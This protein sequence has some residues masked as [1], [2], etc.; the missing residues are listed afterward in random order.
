MTFPQPKLASFGPS[1]QNKSFSESFLARYRALFAQNPVFRLLCGGSLNLDFERNSV[2]MSA[3]KIF[4]SDSQVTIFFYRIL[5]YTTSALKRTRFRNFLTIIDEVTLEAVQGLRTRV[6]KVD[7]GT[8]GH[9]TVIR[10]SKCFTVV[11]SDFRDFFG[12]NK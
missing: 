7:L 8:S 11:K 3:P 2:K 9:P 4:L 6:W 1:N 5:K 10:S 12:G